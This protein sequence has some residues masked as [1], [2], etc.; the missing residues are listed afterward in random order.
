MLLPGYPGDNSVQGL[1]SPLHGVYSSISDPVLAFDRSGNVYYVGI[2]AAGTLTSSSGFN[3]FVA[4][5]VNDGADYAF[6]T[7]LPPSLYN[8]ADKPW[9]TVDTSGG[10]NDGTVYVTYDSFTAKGAIN[11]GV[12]LVRSNDGGITYSLPV[13][14]IKQGF[15]SGA[16]VDNQG[17][18]FVSSLT[19]G[20]SSSFKNILVAV[21]TDA[22][23]SFRGHEIATNV[24]ILPSTLPANFFRV[25][26]VPQIASD[27]HGVYLVWDDF[28]RGN[29]NIQFTKSTDAGITWT[30]PLQVNDVTTGQHFFSTIAV[31][32]GVIS[33]AWYDSRLGQA[34]NGL[35]FGLDVFYAESTDAGHSFSSNVRVT[36]VSF[37]PNI[38]E[39]ADFGATFP[40][41]GDYIQMAASSTAAHIIWA[42]N[43]DACTNIDPFF[44]C[45]NQDIFTSTITL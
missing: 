12:A 35:I 19:A 6:T 30:S 15:F 23:Q 32:G 45:T 25:F 31:S 24:S 14:A 1:A 3:L 33:L 40:F 5:F 8:L 39:R 38:V 20:R 22:G 2:T 43:R 36:S 27:N 28:G 34:P 11:S 10:P 29:S 41:M 42:D 7:L 18:V 37:N 4:K 9:I 17:R 16:T 13:L 26:T 44:G 21:S